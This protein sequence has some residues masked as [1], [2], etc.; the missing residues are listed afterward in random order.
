MRDEQQL[1]LET[2]FGEAFTET[3]FY[4]WFTDKARKAGVPKGAVATWFKKSLLPPVGGGGM[5]AA[6]NHV[7]E[8]PRNPERSGTLHEGSE[9]GTSR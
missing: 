6:R 5:L 2:Q 9:P 1:F 4:N 8:W 3:G 7:G